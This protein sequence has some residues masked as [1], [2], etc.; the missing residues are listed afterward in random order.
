V[1]SVV[2]THQAYL[3]SYPGEGCRSG[4]APA[5]VLPKACLRLLVAFELLGT[6]FD[7]YKAGVCRRTQVPYHTIICNAPCTVA[8]IIVRSDSL[9][10]NTM[11]HVLRV[12]NV[13]QIATFVQRLYTQPRISGETRL[14]RDAVAGG[15]RQYILCVR[16]PQSTRVLALTT[17]LPPKGCASALWIFCTVQPSDALERPP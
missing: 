14:C 15:C 4:G 9:L 12:L 13:Q 1:N 17:T 2:S 5:I 3:P 16:N 8:L 10:Q 7:A 6:L 11:L